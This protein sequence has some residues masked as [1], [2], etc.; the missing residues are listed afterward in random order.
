MLFGSGLLTPSI[1]GIAT[2]L[3][4]GVLPSEW[5]KRWDRGPEKPQ[6]WLRELVRKRVALAKWRT[7]SS[8]GSLLSDPLSL[9]DLFNPATFINAL[10]QQ[11]A[12]QL[13]TAIDRVKMI[14]SWEK[15]NRQLKQ[16]CPLPCTLSNL[17]LQG[18]SF[19]SGYLQESAAEASEITPAPQVHIGFVPIVAKDAQNSSD[20]V[21]VPIYLTPSREEFLVE[22]SMPVKGDQNTWVLSGVSLFLSED[23]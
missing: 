21:D 8:R 20:I 10:R 12:R 22:I 2:S 16:I 5:L 18:A 14:S 19:Q 4:S 23:E 9:G 11:T 3:L 15:D 17:L 7:N 1:Q 13:G 6:A